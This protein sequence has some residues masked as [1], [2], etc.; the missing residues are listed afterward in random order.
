MP[1]ADAF[2][3]RLAPAVEWVVFR[4]R[5]ILAII[6]VAVLCILLLMQVWS[7][8]AARGRSPLQGRVNVAGRPVMFGTVTV[9]AADGTTL[10]TT[11]QPDGRYLLPHVPPGPVRIAVSSPDPQ[12]VFQKAVA[13]PSSAP[14]RDPGAAGRGRPGGAKPKG[15][16]QEDTGNTL[17]IAM[18]IDKAPPSTEGASRP[19]HAGWFRIPGRYASPATS[20]LRGTVEP[21]GS[22]VDFNLEGTTA[23][24]PPAP[25]RST[26]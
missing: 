19:E 1:T 9:V 10:T 6:V 3:E 24:T 26:K 12:T 20:G 21:R 23:E 22:T 25:A 13:N 4:F 11:I 5:R 14:P 16:T 7:R 17:S 8:V 18:P 2:L 15:G